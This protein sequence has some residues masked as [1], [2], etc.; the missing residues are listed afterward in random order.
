MLALQNN[1]DIA[2]ARYNL[3]IADTDLLRARSGL[4]YPWRELP[5][6][7]TARWAAAPVRLPVPLR[8]PRPAP[9]VRPAPLPQRP[10]RPQAHPA[11]VPAELRWARAER[12]RSQWNHLFN[13][14]RRSVRCAHRTAGSSCLTGTVQ[15]ARANIPQTSNFL[16]GTFQ[17]NQN[18]NE[19]NFSYTQGFLPGETLAIT[20]NNNRITNDANAPLQ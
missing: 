14:G 18:T 11:E 17:L 19:Y 5:A 12:L 13:S 8:P 20:F 1:F 6:C 16:T 9:P 3:D 4:A 7:A 2:I 15:L 10:S